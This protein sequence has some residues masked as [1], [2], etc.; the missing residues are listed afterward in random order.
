M[1][2]TTLLRTLKGPPISVL[3]A[4]LFH[5]GAGLGVHRIA[6]LTG[7]SDKPVSQAL[8]LLADL[9][10]AQS[11]SRYH[12]WVAT[13]HVRQLILGENR[14]DSTSFQAPN[15]TETFRL[16]GSSSSSIEDDPF[17]PGEG[18]TTTT[19]TPRE[20]DIFRL[21]GEWQLIVGLLV[22]RCT[23]PRTRALSA[24]Q[25]CIQRGDEPDYTQWAILRWL[26]YCQSD[27]GAGINNRGAYIA[28][29][30]EQNLDC[31]EW[32]HSDNSS[33]IDQQIQQL[34]WK[35]WPEDYE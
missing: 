27:D 2:T 18:Q 11:H 10:L 8:Q 30:L 17:R 24:V 21:P 32:H 22:D 26:S 1:N 25:K 23:T 34:A 33:P 13:A 14:D 35:L 28:S 9:Q 31:P 3:M 20:T 19:T 4:L 7:Y 6:R 5:P 29:R 16:P 15:E 12:G